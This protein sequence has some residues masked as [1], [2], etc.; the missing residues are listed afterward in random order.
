[1]S[2]WEHKA[3]TFGIDEKTATKKLNDLARDGWDYVGPL[4]N[5]LVAFKRF[6]RVAGP[7]QRPPR[8]ELSSWEGSWD[9]NDGAA[10]KIKGERFECSAAGI[11][12]NGSMKIVEIGDKVTL[13]DMLVE[14]GDVKGQTFKAIFRFD[15]KML[16]YCGTYGAVRPTEF[17]TEGEY[18]HLQWK[19]ATPG[20]AKLDMVP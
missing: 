20:G 4:G 12:R 19:R 16:E 11:Q 15:G 3:V 18:Y 14:E 1:M 17:K 5:G 2:H 10:M 8:R 7:G 6:E 13:V 9:T